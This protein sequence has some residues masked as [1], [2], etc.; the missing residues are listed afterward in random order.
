MSLRKLLGRGGGKGC[1][2][3]FL[4]LPQF[5][6]VSCI[7]S[8]LHNVF[9]TI[10]YKS[11]ILVHFYFLFLQRLSILDQSRVLLFGEKLN[12]SCCFFT[13]ESQILMTLGKRP[14][15][16]IVAKGENAGN[17]HFLLFPQCFPSFPNQISIFFK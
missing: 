11:Q 16:N 17:Q 13:T 15:E 12:T 5:M 6:F 7:F 14:P 10:W 2:Q 1:W 4:P 8:F 3:H 9:P